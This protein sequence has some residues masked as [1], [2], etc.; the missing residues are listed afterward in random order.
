[1]TQS[2]WQLTSWKILKLFPVVFEWKVCVFLTMLQ[3]S[4]RFLLQGLY[5]L[6]VSPSTFFNLERTRSSFRFRGLLYTTDGCAFRY[7]FPFS[8]VWVMFQCLFITLLKSIVL[9]LK[10]VIN[11]VM[12]WS[13]FLLVSVEAS[14]TLLI[15]FSK[16]FSV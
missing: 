2:D 14:L 1:M 7:F 15:A 9:E 13:S 8:V 16:C 11:G 10:C 5:S 4:H 12:F 6:A 3:F